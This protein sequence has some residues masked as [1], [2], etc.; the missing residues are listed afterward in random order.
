MSE[1]NYYSILGL[2]KNAK[3]DEI[4]KAFRKLALKYHPD[5]NYGNQ[6][7]ERKFKEINEA[8]EIL[9]DE[10]KRAAYDRH[11]S[12]AFEQGGTTDFSTHGS[13][14]ED[15]TD[16]FGD[17]FGDFMGRNRKTSSTAEASESKYRGSDLRYNV[18]ITLENAYRGLS[19]NIRFRTFC[20]CIECNGYGT[21][22]TV[23]ASLCS[24]C[25]GSG[26]VRYQQGFFM[27]EKTCAACSGSGSIIRNPCRRCRGEGRYKKEKNLLI[28]IPKGV[29]NGDK[30]KISGEGES[31]IR[32]ARAGDLYIYVAI[33]PHEFYQ[34][35]GSDLYCSAPATMI[36]SVLG[37]YIQ[38]PTIDGNVAKVY[39]PAG[40]QY[41]TK[42]RVQKKGMPNPESSR[43]GDIYVNINVELPVNIS[44]AQ[45]ELLEKF[46][47]IN[48]S[49]TN[50]KTESFF[51]KVKKF[52]SDFNN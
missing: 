46:D 20:K 5:K 9:K 28:N 12:S 16:V 45:K 39:I 43:Y 21:Q 19:Q 14:F 49:G 31:G 10:K 37:G 29:Q 26:K 3:I 13:G 41:G 2:N 52:V 1:K 8:Y 15:F 25:R 17:I 27:I 7:S 34:R 6:E 24:S 47:S 22:S 30:I 32:N 51:T 44:I 4:K 48:Q 40:T 23:G 11:G 36:T 33:K 18:E 38:I 35:E 50:P 42:L